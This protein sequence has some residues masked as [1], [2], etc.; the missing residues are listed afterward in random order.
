[1]EKEKNTNGNFLD[2]I[3][4]IILNPLFRI[5][6]GTFSDKVKFLNEK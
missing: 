6:I 1:M 2:F 3:I 4:N 5:N